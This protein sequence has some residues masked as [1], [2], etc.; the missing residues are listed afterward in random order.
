MCM[1]VSV[2]V[3]EGARLFVSLCV[4]FFV[5]LYMCVCFCVC[6]SGFLSV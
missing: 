4:C 6:L 3:C 1:C 2:C 5:C